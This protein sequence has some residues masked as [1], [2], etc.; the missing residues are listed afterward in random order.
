MNREQLMKM[1]KKEL[2]ARLVTVGKEAQDKSGEELTALMDEA[3]TIGEI[4]D[5]IKAREELARAAAAAATEGEEPEDD[6][7]GGEGAETKDKARAE[8]GKA[9]KNGKAVK[10]KAKA[11]A[12]PLNTITTATGV[13]MPHHT[14]PDISPTF[15]NVSSLIDRVKTVPLVGGESYQRPYVK[16]YGD[17]RQHRRGG[18]LQHI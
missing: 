8:S 4:L 1:S 9:L 17:G 14:S 15:N 11:I 5:E 16:S 7:K 10:F 18:R 2:K 6:T 3:R 13:V 12:K